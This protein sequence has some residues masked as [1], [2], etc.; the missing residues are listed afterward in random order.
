MRIRRRFIVGDRG[1]GFQG[2]GA[3]VDNAGR[4]LFGFSEFK[5]EISRR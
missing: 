1:K 3:V 4:P 5:G 2:F